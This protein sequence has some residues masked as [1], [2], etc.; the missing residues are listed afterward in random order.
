MS[1]F[2][3]GVLSARP[4]PGEQMI[5][6]HSHMLIAAFGWLAT[7]ALISALIADAFR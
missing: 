7:F 1:A 3:R 6:S 4:E 2:S 5:K